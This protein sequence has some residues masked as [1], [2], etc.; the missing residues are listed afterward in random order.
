MVSL[1]ESKP[2]KNT[3]HLHKL[4]NIGKIFLTVQREPMMELV[5]ESYGVSLFCH[6]NR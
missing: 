5:Y 6:L 2:A 4:V 1:V 3:S